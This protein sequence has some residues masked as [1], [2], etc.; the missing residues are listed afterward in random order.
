MK[1]DLADNSVFI[2]P[3]IDIFDEYARG[4]EEKEDW[5]LTFWPLKVLHDFYWKFNLNDLKSLDCSHWRKMGI[6]D[7][8]VL[9]ANEDLIQ[10]I[11]IELA[12]NPMAYVTRAV[13]DEEEIYVRLLPYNKLIEII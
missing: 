10:R 8:A 5:Q 11:E 9:H 1:C 4:W 6:P 13:C 12:R 2:V 7:W 3:D